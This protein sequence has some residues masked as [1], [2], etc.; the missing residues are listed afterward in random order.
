MALLTITTRTGL[1]PALSAQPYL[2][3]SG[4][5]VQLQ[6][7]GGTPPYTW[8]LVT[9]LSG[10]PPN[11]PG[12]LTLDPASGT[13]SGTCL[14]GA[15]YTFTAQVADSS[16]PQQTYVKTFSIASGLTTIANIASWV[17]GD[18]LNRQDLTTQAQNAA[19]Y[20]YRVLCAKVPFEEL[21]AVSQ[22]FS[23]AIGVPTYDLSQLVPPLVGIVNIR[24]TL[25]TSS[26]SGLAYRRR[27]RRSSARLFDSLS[28]SVNGLPSTYART[29][30]L[31]IQIN[32]PP[33]Q[34]YPFRVRYW[35][36]PTEG[37]V[38][39]PG[40][41]VLVTPPEWDELI[42]WETAWRVLNMIGQEQRAA[43]LIA[44]EPYPRQRPGPKKLLMM[45]QGII[46][47]LWNELLSTHSQK[48]NVDEDFNINPVIR[49]Y[50]VASGR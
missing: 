23:M 14:S 3:N 49:H 7:S 28:Y 22:E 10:E 40:N 34:P 42:R 50:S 29:Q 27:L 16:S 37:T 13:L 11:F 41:I 18:Y 1:P 9:D 26:G 5:A 35:S 43:T 24:V 45:G 44:P 4:A 31:Q 47:R 2:D 20:F 36:R 8:S 21:H 33:N 32:P 48:E 25:N 19:L 39:G 6:A 46:P 12:W 17:T 38:T 15:Q 30:G